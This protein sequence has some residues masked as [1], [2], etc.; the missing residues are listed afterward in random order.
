MNRTH[1]SITFQMLANSNSLLDEKI[2]IFR[3]LWSKSFCLK[4]AKDLVT[5]NKSHL[6]NPMRVTKDNTYK[7]IC[8][9]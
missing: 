9:T 4:D 3:N 2:Q 1:L 8:P 6:S 7:V 5:S